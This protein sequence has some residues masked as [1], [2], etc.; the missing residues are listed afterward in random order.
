ML[1]GPT[2]SIGLIHG[3]RVAFFADWHVALGYA[4]LAVLC[5]GFHLLR[6]PEREPDPTD[7]I[8]VDAPRPD[9]VDGADVSAGGGDAVTA[10]A[11]SR[12]TSA[13]LSARS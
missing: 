6:V 12:C 13:A 5:I 4:F 9:G 3:A 8:D 2:A 7:P 10:V 11:M 1:P